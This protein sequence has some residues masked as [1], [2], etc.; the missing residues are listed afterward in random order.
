M[1]KRS[2]TRTSVQTLSHIHLE[3]VRDGN[4]LT[5]T[6]ENDG[7]NASVF[8]HIVRAVLRGIS[9]DDVSHINDD[10]VHLTFE[11]M[12]QRDDLHLLLRGLMNRACTSHDLIHTD[13]RNNKTSISSLWGPVFPVRSLF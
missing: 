12:S 6:I 8:T 5:T 13:T 4:D 9:P 11:D 2:R 10:T 3:T 7:V 1:V